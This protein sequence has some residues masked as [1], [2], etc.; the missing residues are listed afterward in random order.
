M[1]Y[2]NMNDI[3]IRANHIAALLNQATNFS[4]QPLPEQFKDLDREWC[5]LVSI[6]PKDVIGGS[7]EV[8]EAIF[9]G[10]KV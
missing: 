3:R 8:K 7:V 9:H 10:Q 6:K 2:R 1:I 5:D 4:R